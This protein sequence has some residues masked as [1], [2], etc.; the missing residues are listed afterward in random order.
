MKEILSAKELPL[1]SEKFEQKKQSEL[2]E[3]ERLRTETPDGER[4]R[5]AKD[6]ENHETNYCSLLFE[7]SAYNLTVSI[8]LPWT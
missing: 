3:R 7:K 2:R 1:P 8:S 5:E 4:E 6:T